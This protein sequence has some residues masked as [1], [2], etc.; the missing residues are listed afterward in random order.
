MTLQE[1]VAR[2][3]EIEQLATTGSPRTR[4][5]SWCEEHFLKTYAREPNGKFAVRLPLKQNVSKLRGSK[6][7]AKKRFLQLE[8]NLM[9]QPTLRSDYVNFMAE[10]LRL[11][12]MSPVTNM[13][14]LLLT[15]LYVKVRNSIKLNIDGTYFWTDSTIVLNRLAAETMN[16]NIF[17]YLFPGI[18][19]RESGI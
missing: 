16:E 9:K 13:T 15:K 19:N 1:Q 5:E 6:D 17:S 11:G 8:R 10:Y 7:I 2:F 18:Y 14:A 3:W 4:V 12:H